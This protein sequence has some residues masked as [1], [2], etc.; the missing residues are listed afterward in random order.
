[1]QYLGGKSSVAKHFAPILREYLERVDGRFFEPFTGGFNIMPTIHESVSRAVCSDLHPGLITL[2]VE[3]QAGRFEPPMEL[4]EEEWTALRDASDWTNPMSAFAAFGCSYGGMEW[5]CYA[6]DKTGKRNFAAVGARSLRKKAQAMGKVEFRNCDYQDEAL[7]A[8]I[9]SAP[10]VLYCDPPYIGTAE[11]GINR[12]RFDSFKFWR[13]CNARANAGASVLVSEFFNPTHLD[14]WKTIWTKE[15]AVTV[16]KTKERYNPKAKGKYG[17][18]K[19]EQLILV[20]P[21]E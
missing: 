12:K 19:V 10:C 11:Y 18:K 7:A 1:M 9:D 14:N 2:Y 6:R 15:R 17:K 20:E 13:W 16:A 8:E 3:L 21:T 4:T 5:S